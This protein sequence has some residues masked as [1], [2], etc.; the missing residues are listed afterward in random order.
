[1]SGERRAQVVVLAGPNG[2]GKSSAAEALLPS[3]GINEFVNADVIAAGL[4]P[5]N[6]QAAAFE[7]GRIM[8]GRLRELIDARA[9]F[10]LESTLSGRSMQRLFEEL[11]AT[12]YNVALYY[13]WIPSPEFSLERVRRRVEV[14]GHDVPAP[15]VLRRYSRGVE[16][17]YRIYRPMAS[18]WFVQ[19]G[20]SIGGRRRI[21]EGRGNAVDVVHDADIWATIQRQAGGDTMSSGPTKR[22]RE[23][24]VASDWLDD[25]LARADREVIL[26]HRRA[27][28]PLVL[29]RDGKVV[30]VDPNTVALPEVRELTEHAGT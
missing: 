11:V 2:A 25:V 14:G 28:V 13:F 26:R 15:D 6:P 9:D 5:G 16:N 12:S 1:M 7:A 22:V 30:H 3:L 18:S 4:S 17:F 20:R 10:A 27:G 19:D 24:A 21:A 29:W 23:T 8:L